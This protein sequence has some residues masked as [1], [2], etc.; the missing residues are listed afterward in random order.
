MGIIHDNRAT[1]RG[2][3]KLL[4]GGQLNKGEGGKES[5]EVRRGWVGEEREMRKNCKWERIAAMWHG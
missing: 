3:C 2:G 5:K 1:R 4:E